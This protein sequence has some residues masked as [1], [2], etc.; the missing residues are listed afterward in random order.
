M[1][2]AGRARRYELVDLADLAGA[3]HVR[4]ACQNLLDE[5]ASRAR[6][7][8]DK[9]GRLRIGTPAGYV[10][11]VLAIVQ[12]DYSVNDRLM[13]GSVESETALFHNS[14]AGAVCLVE[15]PKRL[16]IFALAIEYCRQGKA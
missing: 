13:L 3:V 6:H 11:E 2:R 15:T 5:R 1:R 12:T 8:D 7:A 16:V 14:F 9:D 4:M 10:L